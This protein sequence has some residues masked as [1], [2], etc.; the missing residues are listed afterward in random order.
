MLIPYVR[1]HTPISCL[2][3]CAQ[4]SYGWP[5]TWSSAARTVH[6]KNVTYQATFI[7]AWEQN[8]FVSKP[9]QMLWSFIWVVSAWQFKLYMITPNTLVE[10]REKWL[11]FLKAIKRSEIYKYVHLDCFRGRWFANY[12]VRHYLF[13]NHFMKLQWNEFIVSTVF[14]LFGKL[15]HIIGPE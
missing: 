8:Y 2:K 3:T 14:K 13:F 5:L 12:L 7:K 10:K 4:K 1:D 11:N 15:F 6:S 9:S